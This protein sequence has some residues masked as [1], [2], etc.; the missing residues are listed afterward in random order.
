[1]PENKNASSNKR[2]TN[3]RNNRRNPQKKQ[4]ET[5][6]VKTSNEFRSFETSSMLSRFYFGSNIF[7]FYT[8]E[9]LKD[10][11]KDP[12]GNNSSVRK[13]S[14]ML[15]G[16]NGSFTNTVDYMVAMP[17]LSRVIVPHGDSEKKKKR[18]KA[19][20]EETLRKIK[21]KEFIRDTL[22]TGMIDGV[23]FK[24]F[25]T[26]PR[27][28]S[29][30]KFMSDYDVTSI[31]E[32]NESELN[33]G[34]I[35]LP[36]DYTKIVQKKDNVYVLAFNLSYFDETSGE[37]V[38]SKLRKYPK[39]IRDAYHTKNRKGNWVILDSNKT[40]VHKIR[41]KDS[42]PW[43]RPLVLAAINDILYSDYFTDTKRGVLDDMNSRVCYQTFPEGQQK[44]TS[45]LTQKQQEA[46]H[47]A[48]KGAILNNTGGKKF[49]SVAA[50]TKIDTIDT[51]NTD[52]FD[53]KYESNLNNKIA[54]DLGIASALLNGIGSG[55]HS[56]QKTNL[57]LITSQVFQ[58]IKQIEAELNKCISAN[59]IKDKKNYVEVNYLP[60][61]HVNKSEMVGY[62]KE[63]YLQ[64]CGSISLW[65]AACGI[66][67]EAFFTILDSEKEDGIYDKY[68]PHAT[69]YTLSPDS[70]DAGR[71]MDKDSQNE[72]T[73]ESRESRENNE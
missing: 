2:H 70:D 58:W 39:E 45:A 30:N 9:M 59:I 60:I 72:G 29:K 73:L 57:E 65:A 47:N 71:P 34:I 64:G 12:I 42:E 19:L 21:D 13:L 41:S 5:N 62:A 63:L 32:I 66:E 11:V 14:L 24:Y 54:L 46:Q 27:P 53:D 52:I 8:P 4:S 17:T 3:K 61:T 10:L 26:T 25:E 40:I 55:S 50:G 16:T 36:P 56:S 49:F 51:A 38:E 43:G 33:V 6:S 67:P 37:S 22:F 1:M 7:N 69:S 31:S 35:T 15:Y 48:V 68:K 28:K 20:M 44:G 23:S 18:N